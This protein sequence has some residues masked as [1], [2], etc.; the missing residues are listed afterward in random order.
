MIRQAL[1]TCKPLIV[2]ANRPRD[3]APVA[4]CRRFSHR[5]HYVK[6]GNLDTLSRENPAVQRGSTMRQVSFNPQ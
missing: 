5:A 6:S 1:E 3:C 2:V 4:V